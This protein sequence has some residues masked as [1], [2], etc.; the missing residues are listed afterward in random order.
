M[1]FEIKNRFSGEIQFTAEIEAGDDTPTS[2]KIGLAVK[3]A[4]KT[5]A[6]LAGANLA[7]AYLA[8]ASLAGA[9]LRLKDGSEAKMVGKRPVLQIGPIGSRA[10]MLSAYLTDNGVMLQTGCFGPAPLADFV[11]A[12]ASQHGDNEHAQEYRAAVALIEAHAVLWTPQ[13]EVS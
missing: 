4:V 3:W 1:K 6:N 9:N 13:V 12:V 7:D 2:V 10:A 5:R 8:G 11:S